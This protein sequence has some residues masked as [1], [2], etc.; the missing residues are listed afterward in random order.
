MT[1]VQTC[2][3]PICND[4]NI[5]R[6]NANPPTGQN[7]QFW[8]HFNG[9][10]YNPQFD[11]ILISCRGNSEIWII[12]H[13]TT[14]AQAAGRTGGN[15]GKGGDLIYR[16]GNPVQYKLGSAANQKLWQQHCCTWI[17]T[18][19][20]GGGNILI[21][22][23]GV[24]RNFTTVDEIIPPVDAAG[25]Y[26]R[27]AGTAFGPA[28]YSWSYTNNPP[29][30]FYC[31]D[32]GGAEREPNGNT[33]ITHGTHGT[34]FEVTTHSTT[35]WYYIN[36][37][38]TTPLAQG[39]VIPSDPHMAG[40]WFNEVF[41]VHRYATNYV[42]LVNKD[43]TPRG[44][45]ETYTGAATDTIGLGLP[46]AW[47]RA[48]FGSLSAVTAT[49]DHDGDGLS[50][51]LEYQYGTD[52]TQW[53]DTNTWSSSS[54]VVLTTLANPTTGGVVVGGGT[55][56]VGSNAM[57]TAIASNGWQF[58]SWDD[59]TKNNPYF[60]LVPA[61]NI[62]YTANFS[63]TAYAPGDVNGDRRVTSADALLIN[64]V[65]VGL[66][67]NTNALF[68]TTGFLN[69]DVNQNGA[70]SGADSLLINQV[71]VGLRTYVVTK[72]VP[73]VRTNGTP[74]A[75]IIYGIGFPT[76]TVADVTI[77]P[78]VNLTLSNVV[79]LGRESISALVPAVGGI[80]TGTVNV[81]ASP[82]NGVIS[83]GRFINQ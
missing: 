35:A 40:Q 50:D 66:R 8:N 52:P 57:V 18:N 4:L 20:P 69:G 63:V 74:T 79:V 12:D 82:S 21:F 5:G 65:L 77:G 83:F 80:G 61:T 43:L 64:Q 2:A 23:N 53:T 38:T 60:I 13:S 44:T 70:V 45:V 10:D 51:L 11:Q 71:I 9:I 16:W 1:G 49:S 30:G 22:D 78:P 29:T 58:T 59:G 14:T 41:K 75:V 19:Y 6:I 28:G 72:I 26:V 48:H 47:V 62:T 56:L 27:T 15:S 54:S 39:S 3:L 42:G 25:N 67:S 7:Q 31:S 76:N 32:I 34:L 36:P 68:A 73:S 37:E 33:L 17:P 55:Y 81:T 24:G 46:D